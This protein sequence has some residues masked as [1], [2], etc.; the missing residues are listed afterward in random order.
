MN[1]PIIATEDN[2]NKYLMQEEDYRWFLDHYNDIYKKYGKIYVV[3]RQKEIIGTYNTY[4]EAVKETSKAVPL[5]EFIVQYCNGDSTA[6]TG[7]IAS[8]NFKLVDNYA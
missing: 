4:A 7:Y 8:T 2:R 3:V 5:G 6:Y 1:S